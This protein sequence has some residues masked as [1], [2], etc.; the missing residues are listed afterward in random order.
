VSC[1]HNSV[2]ASFTMAMSQRALRVDGGPQPHGIMGLGKTKED[3]RHE[4]ASHEIDSSG[5]RVRLREAG[6]LRADP[7]F[8]RRFWPDIWLFE[9]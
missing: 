5:R 1:E 4:Q 3:H 9:S 8:E 2:M 7:P 6:V